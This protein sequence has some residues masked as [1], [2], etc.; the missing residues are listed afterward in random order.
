MG[1][2]AEFERN[3]ILERQREDIKLAKMRGA[4][5]DSKKVL[6]PQQIIEMKKMIFQGKKKTDIAEILI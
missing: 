1:A 4:Y 2:F 5:K 3:L 6:N